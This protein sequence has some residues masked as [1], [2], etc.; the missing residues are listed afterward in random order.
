MDETPNIETEIVTQA[1]DETPRRRRVRAMFGGVR[2]M[3]EGIGLIRG[4]VGTVLILIGLSVLVERSTGVRPAVVQ[5]GI[6]I[7]LL[8][9]WRG[10]R[11]YGFLLAGSIATGIGVAVLLGRYLPTQFPVLLLLF[12][13]ASF[14]GIR[15]ASGGRSAWA[16]ITSGILGAVALSLAYLEL[17]D[18]VPDV[19][20]SYALP[21]AV[22]LFGALILF[23][24]AVPGLT[25]QTFIGVLVAVAVLA[26]SAANWDA[27]PDGRLLQPGFGRPRF[28]AK[29][30]NSRFELPNGMPVEVSGKVGFLWIQN[31]LPAVQAPQL[32]YTGQGYREESPVTVTREVDKVRVIF[33]EK[34]YSSRDP[35]ELFLPEGV[36]L[37]VNIPSGRV[38]VDLKAA[39]I[40]I[41]GT[42]AD[43][44]F[45]GEVGDLK[46]ANGAGQVSVRLGGGPPPKVLVET[47][48]GHVSI[49]YSGDP[50]IEVTTQTGSTT[51]GDNQFAPGGTF[52]KTGT[53]GSITVRSVSGDVR[54]SSTNSIARQG[55]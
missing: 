7:L 40:S 34:V 53:A 13:A 1:N 35:S 10:S 41:M 9:V 11:R 21:I 54:V 18:R 55:Y 46:I 52:S 31:G 42:D 37:T 43:V 32:T 24:R 14:L 27:D 25:R 8:I 44:V 36:T 38:H 48:S 15:L 22:I 17:F 16:A 28:D 33:S 19:S 47:T 49:L 5:L 4:V 3:F 50:A 23:Q 51:S 45:Q 39:S 26:V 29:I 2:G 30:V 12:L 6:G 20:G